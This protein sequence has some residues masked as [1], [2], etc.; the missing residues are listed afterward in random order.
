MTDFGS[1]SVVIPVKNGGNRLLEVL[2]AVASQKGVGAEEILLIDSGSTD[3]ALENAIREFSPSVVRISPREFGHGKTRN[4]AISNT[5]TD[6][7]AL[8]TQDAVPHDDYWLH[9]LTNPFCDPLVAGS[10]GPHTAHHE[11]SVVTKLEL[12]GF[13]S[14]L[15]EFGDTVS[16]LNCWP[17]YTADLA[18]RQ[19]SHFFS[20]N[21]ACLRRSVWERYPYPDINF[22]EDQSW[23]RTVLEAGY[24]KCFAP[25]ALVRHSHEFIGKDLFQRSFDEAIA[26]RDIF[27]YKSTSGLISG[28]LAATK[29]GVAE[30]H[31]ALREGESGNKTTRVAKRVTQHLGRYLGQSSLAPKLQPK[32]SREL[33]IIEGKS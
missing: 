24:T 31:I 9:H 33:R 11:H 26:M 27:G 21:N 4:L 29:K 15:G 28:L 17:R 22:A 13:F 19:R 2:S 25:S 10:F 7:V 12:E 16:L 32:L 20:D 3:G 6:L 14:E 1:V 18:F 8:L 30:A 5:R 23:A